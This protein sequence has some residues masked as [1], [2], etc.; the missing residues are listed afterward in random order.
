MHPGDTTTLKSATINFTT[1]RKQ[2]K[3]PQFAVH[4]SLFDFGV[5]DNFIGLL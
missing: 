2:G 5:R 1:N 3:A 4:A